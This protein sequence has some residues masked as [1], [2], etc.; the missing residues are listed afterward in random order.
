M[1]GV[2]LAEF[3]FARGQLA[4]LLDEPGIGLD[5]DLVQRALRGRVTSDRGLEEPV[6][7]RVTV[8]VLPLRVGTRGV[9]VVEVK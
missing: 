8:L 3:P 1:D 6:E 9:E 2:P 7:N 5:E 4:E